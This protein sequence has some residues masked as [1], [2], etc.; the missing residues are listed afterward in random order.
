MTHAPDLP[1]DAARAAFAA[2][3]IFAA[4]HLAA[5][6]RELHEWHRTGV[7]ADGR[8]RELGAI[9]SFDGDNALGHAERLVESFAIQVVATI[10]TPIIIPQES[11]RG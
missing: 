9:F 6:C 5:C 10:T 2:A 8:L 4:L 11:P 3:R 7:L 1:G